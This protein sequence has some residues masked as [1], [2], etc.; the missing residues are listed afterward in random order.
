VDSSISS[1]EIT[2]VAEFFR[3]TR[4]YSPTPLR[5]LRD[6]ARKLGV[7]ELYVKDESARLGL[8]SFKALGVS[9]AIGKL[10]RSGEIAARRAAGPQNVLVCASAGN[11]GRAVAH[12]ARVNGF[13]AR[14][15]VSNLVGAEARQRI[16]SEG[17]EVVVIDGSYD[18]SVAASIR[19][20][21]SHGSMLI[22]DMSWPG[23]E[24]VPRLIMA[25]YT[26]LMT[27][28]SE[29]WPSE[30]TVVIAQVGVG[31]LLG[32]VLAWILAKK[33]AKR[34]AIIAAEPEGAACLR[35]S[36]EA[37]KPVT[38]PNT[39]DTIMTGLNCATVSH[40]V[41]P[42][43]RANV[44]ACITISDE[45]SRRAMQQLANPIG[46]DPAANAGPSGACGLG[47]L[48][49]AM[50]DPQYASLKARFFGPEAR[51]LLVNSEVGAARPD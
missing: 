7:G 27:E 15:Y 35:A 28:A 50:N 17:A 36:L 13:G 37:A 22:S 30:A 51:I 49:V 45:D 18:D 12:I 41:W 39:S 42:M 10:L 38:L 6:L 16:A 8:N 46:D 20:A 3:A 11:H 23:Y 2:Q 47:A 29:Q 26:M 44:D 24:K 1:G 4:G 33:G 34:P 48:M 32:G 9:Y 40:L 19:D 14:V 5:R 43:A 31:G 21:E 25:G